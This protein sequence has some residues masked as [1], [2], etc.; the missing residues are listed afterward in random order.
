MIRI[1]AEL[2]PPAPP[3]PAGKD[4]VEPPGV[5][6]VG[7]AAASGNALSG[8]PSASRPASYQDVVRARSENDTGDSADGRVTPPVPETSPATMPAAAPFPYE[9]RQGDRR[10]QNRPV[11]LDTRVNRG[12]RQAS[13]DGG[14]N[15]KV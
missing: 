13:G 1:P 15:I 12:R 14:I 4:V 6:Q 10:Q 7:A 9:R 5:E 3:A 11:L 8:E 2:I